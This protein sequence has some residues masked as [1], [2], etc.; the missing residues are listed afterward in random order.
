MTEAPVPTR[1][2][3]QRDYLAS[4]RA[5]AQEDGEI[6]PSLFAKAWQRFGYLTVPLYGAETGETQIAGNYCYNDQFGLYRK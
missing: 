5:R 3:L 6:S 4:L 1:L 2:W